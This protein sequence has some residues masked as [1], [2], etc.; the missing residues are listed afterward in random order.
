MNPDKSNRLI[1]LTGCAIIFI[2]IGFAMSSGG[3]IFGVVAGLCIYGAMLILK[4]DK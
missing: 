3:C 2:L 1:V 4:E